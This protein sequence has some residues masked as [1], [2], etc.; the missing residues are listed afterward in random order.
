MYW[1][2]VIKDLFMKGWSL[3]EIID[4]LQ[5]DKAVKATVTKE[6]IVAEY[7]LN[8]MHFY[9]HLNNL[10]FWVQ[11]MNRDIF[12]QLEQYQCFDSLDVNFE[13]LSQNL[14]DEFIKLKEENDGITDHS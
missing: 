5:V 10:K 14:R 2:N 13:G 1:K 12:K 3:I 11:G 8:W 4:Y 6:I 7:V 9:H